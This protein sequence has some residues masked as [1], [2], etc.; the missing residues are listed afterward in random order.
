MYRAGYYNHNKLKNILQQEADSA[1][2]TQFN[3]I[4]C[5]GTMATIQSK[6]CTSV[7]E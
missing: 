3:C 6:L 7:P 1:H 2:S 4:Y 5:K